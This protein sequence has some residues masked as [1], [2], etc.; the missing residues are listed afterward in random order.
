M[1]NRFFF[2]PVVAALLMGGTAN[3]NVLQAQAQENPFLQTVKPGQ[4][5]KPVEQ[6]TV[7]ERKAELTKTV[8][9]QKPQ[10]DQSRPIAPNVVRSILF[11]LAIGVIFGFWLLPLIMRRGGSGSML[12]AM[13]AC[14]VGISAVN[15]APAI[16]SCDPDY[17]A[18]GINRSVTCTGAD[19]RAVTGVAFGGGLSASNF[20]KPA[21]NKIAFDLTVPAGTATGGY[22][23]ELVTS[24]GQAPSGFTFI[25]WDRGQ[26]AF[27]FE[28]DKRYARKG[29]GGSDPVARQ[30][31]AVLEK[32]TL[33]QGARIE[34][35]EAGVGGIKSTVAEAK[36][37]L[38]GL[39]PRV[40]ADVASAA[41]AAR[42]EAIKASN[43]YV[44]EL[45]DSV[46]REV[47][48]VRGEVAKARQ[49]LAQETAQRQSDIQELRDGFF[50]KSLRRT[51]ERDYKSRLEAAKQQRREAEK[52]VEEARKKAKVQ[53][54]P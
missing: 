22:P 47:V 6:P 26:A 24:S 54:A 14:V 2:V 8:K 46:R 39:E 17:S 19:L 42:D 12:G 18:P 11:G 27:L 35:L 44:N 5:A 45:V 33:D 16:R 31:I 38:D 10:R 51:W 13:L 49:E 20:T 7:E 4:Q 41:A 53:P 43:T 30:K 34:R 9:Q 15:A 29:E 28:L 1:A 23:M 37:V 40:T 52:R 36:S 3:I 25:V 48:T 50:N 21:V 32:R